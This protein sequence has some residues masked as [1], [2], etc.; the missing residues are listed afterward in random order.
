MPV[1]YRFATIDEYPRISQFLDKHWAA[2]HIYVRSRSLFD[3]TFRRNDLWTDDTYSFAV[4][5]D[6][7]ELVGILGGIPFVFNRFGEQSSGVWIVN[8]V[9][10]EDHRRG[11]TAL[12]LLGVF[13]KPP[14]R[15]TI[16]FG[17]NPATAAIYRVLRG[18]VLAEIPRHFL[19]LPH[20]TEAMS[21]FLNA[22]G[23]GW[24]EE[25]IRG[26]TS[27]FRVSSLPDVAKSVC[28]ELPEDWD[29]NDWPRLAATTVGAARDSAY[30]RWRYVCHPSFEHH[31]ISVPENGAN[32]L[33]IWRLEAI[34]K[35]IG[36]GLAEVG[37]IGRLLEFLPTSFHNAGDLTAVFLKE[38]TECGAFGADYYGYHGESRT[39]LEELGFRSTA[40]HA[41]GDSIPSRFQPLDGKGGGIM[42]AMFVPAGIPTCSTAP[43]CPWSWTKSDSDQ[44]RP[45]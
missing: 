23:L 38:L 9:I 28:S 3:W 15:T 13:R 37:R 30:L 14:F 17:I 12:Q 33:A 29:Q 1:Q 27:A 21:E 16:A 24:D 45:N 35:R 4:A 43:N 32:G 42:S 22:A 19:V 40:N 26:V 31:V 11:P 2:D 5:E 6:Q 39:W 10:R 20:G 36:S 44:D 18:Q 41:D 25:R 8:Y 34:R 7:G